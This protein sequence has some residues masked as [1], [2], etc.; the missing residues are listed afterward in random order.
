M[1]TGQGDIFKTAELTLPKFLLELPEPFDP[2]TM[3]RTVSS[4]AS[5][6]IS[7][8]GGVPIRIVDEKGICSFFSSVSASEMIV[9]PRILWLC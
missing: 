9:S 2:I 5:E 6:M 7:I 8:E 3:H 1:T 4:F